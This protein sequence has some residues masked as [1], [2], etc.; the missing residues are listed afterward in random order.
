MAQILYFLKLAERVIAGIGNTLRPLT[1][2]Y[3]Y[4]AAVYLDLYSL[5]LYIFSDFLGFV[6]GVVHIVA[7][8]TRI[9]T[10]T[11]IIPCRGTH[12]R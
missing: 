12:C 11:A 10:T 1:H 4:P 9:S 6:S 3:L 7:E 5:W 8:R 2:K